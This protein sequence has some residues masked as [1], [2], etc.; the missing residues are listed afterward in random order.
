[1]EFND[2]NAYAHYQLAD[3]HQRLRNYEDA[4]RH[5]LLALLLKDESLEGEYYVLGL[6]YDKKEDYKN[7]LKYYNLTLKENPDKIAAAYGKVVVADKYYEDKEAVLKGYEQF[8]EKLTDKRL[9]Y[10]Y[11]DRVLKRMAALKE[12]LFLE[13]EKKE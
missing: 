6:I 1:M 5:G 9:D 7:A 2:K 3:S 13:Q 10:F 11:G 4:E 8:L 12:E